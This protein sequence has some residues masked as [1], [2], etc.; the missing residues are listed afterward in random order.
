[1]NYYILTD[2]TSYHTDP[3]I[4][5]IFTNT[6]TLLS[7]AMDIIGEDFQVYEDNMHHLG[8]SGLSYIKVSKINQSVHP[9]DPQPIYYDKI[10]VKTSLNPIEP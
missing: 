2:T 4:Y 9:T 10:H 6:Q 1:M 7:G 3:L 8:Y 5:G